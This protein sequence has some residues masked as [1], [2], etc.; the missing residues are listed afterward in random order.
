[1][2]FLLGMRRVIEEGIQQ[3]TALRFDSQADSSN[4][5][6]PPHTDHSAYRSPP[7]AD[8]GKVTSLGAGR[9][10]D[11]DMNAAMREQLEAMR[12]ERDAIHVM[13]P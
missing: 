1:M 8:D 11:S 5:E 10:E 12:A 7:E 13:S 6:T 2:P 3:L 9:A 4:L